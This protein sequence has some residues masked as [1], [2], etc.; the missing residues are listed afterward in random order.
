[1]KKKPE[2]KPRHIKA[3]ANWTALNDFL[4]TANLTDCR[5]VLHLE[6]RQRNRDS[7]IKRI[8]GRMQM[9]AKIQERRGK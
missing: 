1:M 9:A 6:E 8:L 7:F 4:R 5:I 2:W 3:L